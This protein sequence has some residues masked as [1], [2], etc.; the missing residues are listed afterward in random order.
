MKKIT[1]QIGD[2][3]IKGGESCLSDNVQYIDVVK[4]DILEN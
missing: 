2:N 3:H 4:Q 1:V